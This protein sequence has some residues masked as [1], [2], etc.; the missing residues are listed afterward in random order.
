MERGDV[1]GGVSAQSSSSSNPSPRH[2]RYYA[3]TF[4][5]LSSHSFRSAQSQRP[6]HWP[7]QIYLCC[8]FQ[9]T[10]IQISSN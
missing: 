6:R 9:H 8:T 10:C 5:A 7:M 3:A 2:S 4:P 1:C